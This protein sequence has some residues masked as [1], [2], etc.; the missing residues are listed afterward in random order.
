VDQF[1]EFANDV[2]RIVQDRERTYADITGED[3]GEIGD[4]VQE[5]VERY[6]ENPQLCCSPSPTR[7]ARR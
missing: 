6:E 3:T 5:F 1:D 7:P 2:P 4:R